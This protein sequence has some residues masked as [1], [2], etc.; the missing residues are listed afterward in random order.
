MS[1][2]VTTKKGVPTFCSICSHEFSQDPIFE[3]ACPTCKAKPGQYCIRP[4]GHSGPFVDFHAER[5]I[6]ALRDGFY[7]HKGN[8]SC[9][10]HSNSQ[11][12]QE[13]LMQYGIGT[14]TNN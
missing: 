12:T 7:D 10:P 14:K 8:G 3:V 5:D 4:S 9:G 2:R 13:L 1:L 11:R 6:V